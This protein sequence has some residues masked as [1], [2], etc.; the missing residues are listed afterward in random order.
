M[1][2]HRGDMIRMRRGHVVVLIEPQGPDGW[3]TV[4]VVPCSGQPKGQRSLQFVSQLNEGT[5]ANVEPDRRYF[6]S[7]L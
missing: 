3:D 1:T 4:C 5:R 2:Y 6:A 7:Q